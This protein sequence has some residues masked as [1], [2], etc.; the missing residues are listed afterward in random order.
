[1]PETLSF[2]A[3]LDPGGSVALKGTAP[4][5]ADIKALGKAAGGVSTKALKAAA[6]LPDG[7]TA[8]ATGG[9]AVLSRLGQ[10]DLGFDGARWWLR[11]RAYTPTAR[12]AAT[13][14]I[15]A[16]PGGSDWSVGIG[17][18]NPLDACRTKVAAIAKANSIQF[19]GKVLTK[20][21]IAV[22]DD[23]AAML[24][25]CAATNVHV[26]A[27]TDADGN[28]QANLGVSVA[29]AEAVIAELVK[30]GGDEGRLYAEGFGES[31][32]VASNDTKAGKAANRRVVFG[33]D[34][35]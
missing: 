10:G 14:A 25:G 13:A 15:A 18:L 6:G 23:L 8:S 16:I 11:A 19:T 34:P 3:S 12:D 17:V 21:S 33:I 30:Q 5:A 24:Q 29:R 20:P 9:I 32:P 22:V 2:A 4:S 31:D 7:F 35:Q 26:Q 1:M 28:A 27:H